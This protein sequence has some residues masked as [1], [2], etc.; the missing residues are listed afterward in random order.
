MSDLTYPKDVRET[1]RLRFAIIDNIHKASAGEAQRM[2]L[3]AFHTLIK[4]AGHISDSEDPTM[5]SLKDH[6]IP[7]IKEEITE[8]MEY[9]VTYANVKGG[10]K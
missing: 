1:S 5:P 6:Y 9:F 7:A 4:I 8:V 3:E 10:E 2:S